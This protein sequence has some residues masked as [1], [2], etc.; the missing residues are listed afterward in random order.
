MKKIVSLISSAALALG[1]GVA[2]ASAQTPSV[3]YNGKLQAIENIQN[4]NGRVQLPFRSIFEMMGAN[5]DYEDSTRKVT[6]TRADKTIEFF[7]NGSEIIVTDSNG[8]VSIPAEI[9]FDYEQNRVMV[10]VRFVSNALGSRVGWDDE[11]KTVFILD[12]YK[13][14]E[15]LKHNDNLLK[16]FE[17]ANNIEKN[18]VTTSDMSV[19]LSVPIPETAKSAELNFKAGINAEQYNT[20]GTSKISLNFTHKNFNELTNYNL[21]ELKD[22]SFDILQT[23]EAVYFK[24]NIGSKISELLPE[25]DK[26]HII[27]SVVKPDTWFRLD[28]SYVEKELGKPIADALFK[29]YSI[30]PDDFLDTFTAALEGDTD[31]TEND[32]VFASTYFNTMEKMFSNMQITETSPNTFSV[33]LLMSKDEFSEIFFSSMDVDEDYEAFVSEM[34]D[35]FDFDMSLTLD[36]KDGILTNEALSFIYN[37]NESDSSVIGLALDFNTK[38]TPLS[39]A[40][41]FTI[42]ENSVSIEA[43]M[44]FI[45]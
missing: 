2:S 42:P 12:A 44:T 36:V 11:T 40:P 35:T 23:E 25:E 17:L 16:Y 13:M 15:S 26:L 41:E 24:T 10:P 22:A 1:L 32:V 18:A 30:T 28:Y 33:S 4:V 21:G 37:V 39:T 5:V 27:Q 20:S 34:Q 38:T 31:V 29:G 7:A 19:N 6:A 45:N 14:T 43:I 3:N 9:G 8:T